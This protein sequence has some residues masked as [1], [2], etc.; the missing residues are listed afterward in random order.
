MC[1]RLDTIL[2]TIHPSSVLIF[3]NNMPMHGGNLPTYLCTV[4]IYQQMSQLNIFNGNDFMA[5]FHWGWSR[6]IKKLSLI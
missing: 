3:H 1:L 5:L 2:I 6:L 4:E